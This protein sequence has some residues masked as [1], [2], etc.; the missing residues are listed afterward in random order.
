MNYQVGDILFASG[1]GDLLLLKAINDYEWSC[2]SFR[3]NKKINMYIRKGARFI[4]RLNA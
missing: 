2:F 3:N 1:Y 4:A